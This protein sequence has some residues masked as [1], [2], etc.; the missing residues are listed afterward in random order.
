MNKKSVW[1]CHSDKDIL[2]KSIVKWTWPRKITDRTTGCCFC[3]LKKLTVS[4]G[5]LERFLFFLM[6]ER[7]WFMQV[8]VSSFD[9]ESISQPKGSKHEE[10]KWEDFMSFSPNDIGSHLTLCSSAIAASIITLVGPSSALADN[11]S[12]NW[13][14]TH[15]LRGK[16]LQ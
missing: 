9:G 2:R 7:S 10:K 3:L 13:R 8:W 1:G 14:D 5:L 4:F 16:N 12:T 15:L 11:F 6:N